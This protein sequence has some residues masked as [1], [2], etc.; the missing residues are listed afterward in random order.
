M[1]AKY[2]NG[3]DELRGI[4]EDMPVSFEYDEDYDGR[5]FRYI[6]EIIGLKDLSLAAD[7]CE[8]GT[9]DLETE[10]YEF[11]NYQTGLECEFYLGNNGEDRHTVEVY[12]DILY[13]AGYFILKSFRF[14]E[15]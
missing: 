11:D 13:I 15:V 9:E 7:I 14:V 4:I 2:V 5:S 8:N 3:V 12:Y 1:S 10:I 6:T